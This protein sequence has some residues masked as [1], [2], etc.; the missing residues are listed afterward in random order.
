MQKIINILKDPSILSKP[1]TKFLKEI[2]NGNES[3]RIT[4]EYLA[5]FS[6][7]R[8]TTAKAVKRIGI[9]LDI[10]TWGIIIGY[11]LIVY[12]VTN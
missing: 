4:S 3:I 12:S 8:L 5:S 6:D 10:M 1:E 7:E 9:E 11:A 2:Y